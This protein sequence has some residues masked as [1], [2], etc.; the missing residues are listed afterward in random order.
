MT[1]PVQTTRFAPHPLSMGAAPTWASEWGEDRFGVFAGFAVAGVTQIMR[2]I[3]PGTFLMG[4]PYDEPGRFSNE[5]PRH[6]VKLTTGFW[7]FDTPCTQALWMAVMDDNPSRFKSPGRPVDGVSWN[8]AQAFIAR[9]N[10][11]IPGLNLGLP[12]E[13]Q[14]EYASRAGTES[15]LYSGPID[16]LG[17]NNAPALDAIAWYGGNSGA[18]FELD[19][20]YDTSSFQAKQYPDRNAGTRLVRL[21]EANAWG[22]HDMLGNVLEWCEDG[23]RMYSRETTIDPVGPTEIGASRVLRGGSWT[24]AARYC[25]SAGRFG[26]GPDDR[27]DTIG[28]RCAQIQVRADR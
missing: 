17:L 23:S 3:R 1:A 27:N 6:D 24:D 22:L 21:K 26:G 8:D 12:T 5:G 16:I 11:L 28:F 2:W 19:N 13:A 7:L 4:S 20:G 14:W 10:A 18:G 15:A 9:I 25:R